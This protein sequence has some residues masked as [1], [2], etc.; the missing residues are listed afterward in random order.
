MLPDIQ[1]LYM[2]YADAMEE[3]Y[4]RWEADREQDMK[5]KERATDNEQD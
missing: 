5:A 4:W 2:A 3:Q 1:D